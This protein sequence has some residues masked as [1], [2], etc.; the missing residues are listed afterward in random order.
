MR[1]RVVLPSDPRRFTDQVLVFAERNSPSAKLA[2]AEG[3]TWVGA[4]ELFVPIL[5][6]EIEPTK[7]LCT[8][9]MLPAVTARLARFLGPKNLMPTA[10][11]GGLGEGAELVERIREAKGAV[12]WKSHEGIV[13]ASQCFFT[14]FSWN[15]TD[16]LRLAIA[17]VRTSSLSD[18]PSPV[19]IS[20]P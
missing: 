11:R 15:L 3:V 7:V 18:H 20:S 17:R 16:L 12:D 8:P 9:G 19:L 14:K 2:I 10:R 6:G 13:R 5:N 1:G 4:E